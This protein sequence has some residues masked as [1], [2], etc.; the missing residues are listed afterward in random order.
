MVLGNSQ[1]RYMDEVIDLHLYAQFRDLFRDPDV[2]VFEGIIGLPTD[3]G[4]FIGLDRLSRCM[5][6][7]NKV[8]NNICIPDHLPHGINI[9]RAVKN[10]S[11]MSK[12]KHGLDV[13]VLSLVTAVSDVCVRTIV[14]ELVAQV[15]SNKPRGTENCDSQVGIGL[16]TTGST[17]VQSSFRDSRHEEIGFVVFGWRG[18]EAAAG[19]GE[20]PTGSRRASLCETSGG[21]SSQHHG[22]LRNS[23]PL[24]SLVMATLFDW[25][26]TNAARVRSVPTNNKSCCR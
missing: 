14:P 21:G 25:I 4:K 13:A 9:L 22:N 17:L 26:G 3:E 6:F 8:D 16:T 12:I 18:I 5:G 20:R 23:L 1:G 24:P 19:R 2:D 7:R 11:C 15:L 10:E